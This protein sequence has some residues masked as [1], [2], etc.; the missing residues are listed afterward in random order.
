M[1]KY[2]KLGSY[3]VFDHINLYGENSPCNRPI[4]MY[5]GEAPMKEF[6][7]SLA[8]ACDV[9]REYG[10]WKIGCL[11]SETEPENATPL[12]DAAK[13][14]LSAHRVQGTQDLLEAAKVTFY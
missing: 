3:G 11:K 7:S 13:A 2:F 1:Y 8:L 6:K 10:C 14:L 9:L 12:T 4:V 5:K